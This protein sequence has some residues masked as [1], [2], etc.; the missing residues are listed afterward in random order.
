MD[1]V[2]ERIKSGELAVVELGRGRGKQRI[3]ADVLQAFIDGRTYR[4]TPNGI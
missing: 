3:P 1:Y 2:Y 4:S